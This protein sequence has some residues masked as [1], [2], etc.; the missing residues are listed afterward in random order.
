MNKI[1]SAGKTYLMPNL[2]RPVS[3]GMNAFLLRFTDLVNSLY[4]FFLLNTKYGEN[5][6]KKRIKGAVTKTIRKDA[7]REI[8]IPVPPIIR[9]CFCR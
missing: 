2:N 1:G 9:F 8:M 7:V 6:I 3:L 4:I 5:E